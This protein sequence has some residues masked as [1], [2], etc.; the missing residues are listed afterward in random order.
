MNSLYSATN[1]A[2]IRDQRQLFAGISFA[3]QAGD[4]LQI[5]GQNGAGKSSLLRILTGL[6]TPDVGD[7]HW[8][9]K[10]IHEDADDF[11]NS[12]HYIGHAN[13]IKLGLTVNEN[14]TLM[15]MRADAS[16]NDIDGILLKLQLSNYKHTIAKHLSAGQRRRIALAKL[17]LFPKQLWILDEPLTS[18][19]VD[20]QIFFLNALDRHA[21]AG[22]IVIA[23]S[24]QPLTISQ[25]IKA[26]GLS[27]C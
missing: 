17:L 19:D 20:T 2:Y 12:L 18:L 9:G 3:L 5:E 8:N 15:G 27:S 11:L 14:L 1:I 24:H 10:S 25:P 7:V 26:L 13:G 6:A 23:S 21:K 16:S 22:G 4:V